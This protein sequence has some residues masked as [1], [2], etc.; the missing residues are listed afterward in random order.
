MV[1]TF[2]LAAALSAALA[3]NPASAAPGLAP[4]I[5]TLITKAATRDGGAHLET[6][7]LMAIDANPAKAPDILAAAAAAAPE[8][9]SALYQA[10]ATAYPNL[11]LTATPNAAAGAAVKAEAEAEKAVPPTSL[12]ENESFWR[13][14]SWNGEAELSGARS[15]G[16]TSQFSLGLAAKAEREIGKWKHRF[17]GLADFEKSQGQTTKERW[18]VNYDPTYAISDRAYVFGLAQYENDRFGGFDYRFSETLGFGYQ[19]FRGERFT[20]HAEVG[21]GARHTKFDPGGIEHEFAA[22]LRTGMEWKV[23]DNTIFSHDLSYFVGTNQRT[24]DTTA[25]LKMRINGALSGRISY[26]YRYNTDVPVGKRATDTVTRA[27]LVYDF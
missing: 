26:N 17:A 2:V 25:A 22:L 9:T 20:L 14:A 16:N 12:E 11:T 24:L 18:L 19:F 8:R 5:Q 21:P 13:L 10:A 27:A 3:A 15:T 23:S 4:E 6:I 1:K 7:V